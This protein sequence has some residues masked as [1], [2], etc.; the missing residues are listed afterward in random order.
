[1]NKTLFP[2]DIKSET[3]GKGGRPEV[4]LEFLSKISLMAPGSVTKIQSFH[5]IRS[6]KTGPYVRA[7]ALSWACGSLWRRVVCPRSGK[8]L[9]PGT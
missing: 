2:P 9:G 8:P 3:T 6:L 5:P 1:M 7:Q 4:T